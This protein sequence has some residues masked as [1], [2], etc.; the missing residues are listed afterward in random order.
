MKDEI[1]KRSMFSKPMSK[2]TRNTGI[3]SGFED[4]MEEELAAE[5]MPPMA[6][7]PQNPE[8]LMN[9]LRGDIRSVDARYLELAQ[10]VG[11]EAASETPP[12]VL[13]ML[14]SQLAA[15]QAPPP[16][17]AGGIGSLA[18]ADQMAGGPMMPPGMEGGLPFPQGGA[19]QAPPTP[20]GMP[21]LRAADGAFATQDARREQM[22]SPLFVPSLSRM[23]E[24]TSGQ[25]PPEQ[26]TPQEQ[27]FLRSYQF[28]MG[29]TGGT[30]RDIAREGASRIGSALSP[31]VQRGMNYLDELVTPFTRPTMRVEPMTEAGRRAV[32]QG[33][34][35]I[36]QGPRGAEMSTGT[37][38]EA[39]N[40]LGFGRIPF[41]QALRE[42][43]LLGRALDFARQNPKTT[44]AGA[45][46]A[47]A[48]LAALNRTGKD[49]PAKDSMVDQIPGQG[50]PLY[51][52]RG[53]RII[54]PGREN[55]PWEVNFV[56]RTREPEVITEEPEQVTPVVDPTK[57]PLIPPTVTPTKEEKA[58]ITSFIDKSLRPEF[59]TK[60][61]SD[62]IKEEFGALEPTFR[63]ILG[64]TK[65]DARTNALLLLADAG[66][67][68][69]STYKPT[70]AMA[71][72]EAMS[73]VPKG[74]ANIVAQARANNIKIKSAA[75]EQAVGN[76]NMQDK[77]ARDFQLKELEVNGRIY[78][79][80][81]KA[82][83]AQQ[84]EA[85]KNKYK[86]GE[87]TLQG[88]IN[89]LLE[90]AK[91]GGLVEEDGGMGLTIQKTKNGSYLGN[92]IKPVKDPV[93][94]KETLPPVV[95]GAI[96]SRWTLRD[97]D[98]PFVQNMGPAPT[99]VETDKGER[100]KLGNTLRSLDNSLKTFDNLRGQY[101]QV[102][103]PGAWFTDKV[104]N[105]IVPLTGGAVRPDVNQV[106]AATR[107]KSGLN[108]VMKSIASANDQGRVAVQEQEWA[109]EI[110][111]GLDNPT[112]FFANKE[113]AAKQLSSMEAQLRNARQQVLTQLGY[114]KNDYVMQPAPTG[115]QNDPFVI[116][117]DPQQQ[118]SM[119]TFLGS[120]IGTLQDPRAM[121]YLRMPNGRVEAF[122]PTQLKGLI[123]K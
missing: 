90:Q 5:E 94:G 44:M 50:P 42:D 29:F 71:L 55:E 86:L 56:D 112:A 19:E 76:V 104:N 32:I 92:Y 109:R 123:P 27:E 51:D 61:R 106:E 105:I 68:F 3:M 98:N 45:G 89:I 10:M 62:R 34:E 101:E 118:R 33:R 40:T 6:R 9:N 114:V 53:N 28:G 65:A 7:T 4:E 24:L 107:L 63:E 54:P 95:A 2:S 49:T 60:S 25:V 26:M 88:D 38:L 69:A 1:L 73:G 64:D 121:V 58:D 102:Y 108:Q 23:N 67:K 46:T 80:M 110:L 91:S 39:A 84:L 116:P 14:Q 36:A 20:D 81:M 59:S 11:E 113:I 47:A 22:N 66:F 96:D 13:A 35:N 75:L 21:P 82:K 15:Q 119:F 100:V 120:T 115:T 77:I 16:P 93:T 52:P 97:T 37:R 30:I 17:P 111:S 70:M 8:I 74:F 83:N 12:E 79:E 122:N 41:T 78:T 48:T 72:G 117:A 103:G 85:I 31:Y 87:I 43:P 18:P 99:T 57:P